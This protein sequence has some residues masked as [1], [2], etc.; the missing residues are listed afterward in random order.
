M[1]SGQITSMPRRSG[2]V[3]RSRSSFRARSSC[4]KE[5]SGKGKCSTR[6]PVSRTKRSV[7]PV[8]LA[9]EGT[10]V[11]WS[12]LFPAMSGKSSGCD[13]SGSRNMM[14]VGSGFERRQANSKRR[15]KKLKTKQ[16]ILLN[17]AVG[18][19]RPGTSSP[20]LAIEPSNRSFG[21]F[22]GVPTMTSSTPGSTIV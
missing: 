11:S 10:E 1:V 2:L 13:H 8:C 19:V 22:D 17:G 12:P 21:F 14:V 6:I 9:R 3:L 16:E 5:V 4:P 20:T 15:R 18:G 7:S